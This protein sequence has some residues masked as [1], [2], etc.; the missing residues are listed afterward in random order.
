MQE[1]NGLLEGNLEEDQQS[2][3]LTFNTLRE[4]N[5]KLS[6][7]NKMENGVTSMYA[8][9]PETQSIGKNCL[10]N[11]EQ[12]KKIMFLN[13]LISIMEQHSR[14]YMLYYL[15][16]ISVRERDFEDFEVISELLSHLSL[17]RRFNDAFINVLEEI[18]HF[19]QSKSHNEEPDDIDEI[20]YLFGILD[21][22]LMLEITKSSK[23]HFLKFLC[24]LS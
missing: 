13:T 17:S 10:L 2:V 19:S 18:T 11:V 3:V 16:K 5:S 4:L 20:G 7:F 9:N 15:V 23:L 21:D 8:N 22:A 24:N 12:V 14:I 6:Q 1:F